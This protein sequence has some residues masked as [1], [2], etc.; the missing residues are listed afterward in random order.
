MENIF[1]LYLLWLF[2]SLVMQFKMSI[3]SPSCVCRSN[4]KMLPYSHFYLP[5]IL[6]SLVCWWN[7]SKWTFSFCASHYWGRKLKEFPIYFIFFIMIIH[8][9][10]FRCSWI[11][12]IYLSEQFPFLIH[13]YSYFSCICQREGI[14][15]TEGEFV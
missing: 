13:S 14:L 6:A 1:F 7:Y 15:I 3:S 5:F 2:W 10:C 9:H 11:Y 8:T 4:I 12:A